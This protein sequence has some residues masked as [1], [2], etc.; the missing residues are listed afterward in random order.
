MIVD[1]NGTKYAIDLSEGNT[2]QVTLNTAGTYDITAKYLGDDKFNAAETAS[3]VSIEIT[4]VHKTEAN[5]EIT[6]PENIK[7]GDNVEITISSYDGAVINVILNGEEASLTDGKLSIANIQAGT[8]VITANIAETEEYTE[9]SATAQFTVT[10]ADATISVSGTNAKVGQASTIT[11]EVTEGASGFAIVNVNGTEYAVDLSKGNTINVI[12]NTAGTY[13]ITAKYLGDDKFNAAETTAVANIEISELQKPEAEISIPTDIKAGDNATIS[14]DIPNATGSIAVIVDG[15]E[16]IVP[17][18]DG[19]ANYT[20]KDIGEGNHGIVVVYDG[21]ENIAGMHATAT[22]NVPITPVPVVEKLATVIE[23][24]DMTTTAIDSSIEPGTGE[25]FNITLKDSEGKAL[26][27]KDVKFGFN[28]KI[29]NKTTDENGVAQLQINLQ[30]YDIYTFA[31]SFLGDDE[32]NATFIVAK[33]TVK[34]QTASLTVPNKS[35]KASAKTKTLTATFKSA[36]GKV[37]ADKKVTFTVNGKTYTATT[38]SKGVASVNVSLSD[39]KTY[40]FTAKFAGDNTYA[41]VTKSAK[42]TIS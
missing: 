37:V 1:I 8:Y 38:D 2:I 42:V 19:K 29:Y 14:I 21:D 30:R 25:Y 40:S 18:V 7:V 24:A 5:V 35:Y 15:E 10:K 32:Y 36:S 33:I 20:I 28:G 31:V 23:Y 12:L 27:N 9:A 22:V 26:A 11:V 39:K 6:V 3:P 41:A 13:D 16:T 34:K 4:E 17:L